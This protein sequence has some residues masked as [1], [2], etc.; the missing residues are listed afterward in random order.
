[1]LLHLR[2]GN[3]SKTEWD[4]TEKKWML[5]FLMR[6]D[7]DETFLKIPGKTETRTRALVSFLARPRREPNFNEEIYCIFGFFFVKNY[8][9]RSGRDGDET[10]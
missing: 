10:K 3:W 4:E 6:R 9:S 5:N 2:Y 7:Q 8:S 1:M